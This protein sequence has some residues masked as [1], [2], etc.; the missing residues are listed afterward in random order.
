MKTVSVQANKVTPSSLIFDD[1]FFKRLYTNSNLPRIILHRPIQQRITYGTWYRIDLRL[2]TEMGLT[3]NSHDAPITLSCHMLMNCSGYYKHVTILKSRAISSENAWE[4]EV[5]K[6]EGFKAQH[7]IGGLEYRLTTFQHIPED[8]PFFITLQ[9]TDQESNILPLCVGPVW[10]SNE[11]HDI[12]EKNGDGWA[13][14]RIQQEQQQCRLLKAGQD[15]YFLVKEQW[16]DGVPGKIWDSALVLADLLNKNYNLLV[17]KRILDLSAGTGY[18]GLAIAQLFQSLPD[19]ERQKGCPHITLSDVHQALDLIMANQR[20]NNI[21]DSEYLKI[22]PLHWGNKSDIKKICSK[23][24]GNGFD[25]IIASDIIY[26][27]DDFVNILSTFRQLCSPNTIIFMGYKP[28][29]LKQN[30][31]KE[32][33]NTCDKYFDVQL[34]DYTKQDMD[35]TMYH[36]MGVKLYRLQLK[37]HLLSFKG[38]K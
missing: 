11:K 7:S 23:Q 18:I 30:E 17:G 38:R 34:I 3:I 27:K 25:I 26:R 5:A 13:H 29:G 14:E 8:Q 12:L 37:T 20:L 2:V 36:R 21:H 32:F 33:F 16:D 6:S 24:P 19:E 35:A 9:V 15:R 4:P 1:H 31:E 10:V 28:R 22:E